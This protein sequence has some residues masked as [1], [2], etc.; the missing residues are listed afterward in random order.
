MPEG[1]AETAHHLTKNAA[2]NGTG[3]SIAGEYRFLAVSKD[4]SSLCTI[5]Q[6]L[7]GFSIGATVMA[8]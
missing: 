6:S 1:R 8:T 3:P 2:L 4:D 5:I 7:A